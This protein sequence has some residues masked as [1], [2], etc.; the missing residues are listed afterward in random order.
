[1]LSHGVAGEINDCKDCRSASGIIKYVKEKSGIPLII[2]V[3]TCEQL[4]FQLENSPLAV[5]LIEPPL[6]TE[7]LEWM[8][9]EKASKRDDVGKFSFF[10]TNNVECAKNYPGLVIPGFVYGREF[11]TANRYLTYNADAAQLIG[12][13]KKNAY[14]KHFELKQIY[15]EPI[16]KESIPA[17]IL[18]SNIEDRD[19]TYHKALK[20]ASE[21][22]KNSFLYVTAGIKDDFHSKVAKDLGASQE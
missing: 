13:M 3:N 8:Q 6:A 9:Y 22:L 17:L 7:S 19:T 2:K 11:D 10:H 4:K 16:F 1:V 18:F 20:Q 14:P 5:A 12:F 21:E 15:T